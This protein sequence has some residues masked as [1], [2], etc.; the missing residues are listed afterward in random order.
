MIY[1]SINPRIVRIKRF[2][3][4]S[5]CYL[6]TRGGSYNSTPY[7]LLMTDGV[8]QG[9]IPGHCSVYCLLNTYQL[10]IHSN[11]K[12]VIILITI[13]Y[14]RMTKYEGLWM[15]MQ[16]ILNKLVDKLINN[17]LVRKLVSFRIK[18]LFFWGTHH[19]VE[20]IKDIWITTYVL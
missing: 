16:I 13:L 14:M 8:P 18:L 19:F 17:K 5:T 15:N 9:A 11:F 6:C 3:T 4:R 20:K 7:T 10:P 1:I 12:V 2:C